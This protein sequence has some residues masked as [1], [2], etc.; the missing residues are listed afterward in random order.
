MP[1][2][3][4]VRVSRCASIG[5]QQYLVKNLEIG[6][7]LV[8]TWDGIQFASIGKKTSCNML[9]LQGKKACW[10]GFGVARVRVGRDQA[11]MR[12]DRKVARV[13]LAPGHTSSIRVR[14]KLLGLVFGSF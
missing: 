5:S 7:S 9:V 14:R 10:V 2:F 1:I 4:G 12:R 6:S 13:E 3:I 11:G 8:R